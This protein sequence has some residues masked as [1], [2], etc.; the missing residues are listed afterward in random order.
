ML[1]AQLRKR[2]EPFNRERE[3]PLLVRQPEAGKPFNRERGAPED[4]RLEVIVP[5]LTEPATLRGGPALVLRGND[6]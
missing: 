6:A 2:A 1:S 3:Q 4:L 5:L